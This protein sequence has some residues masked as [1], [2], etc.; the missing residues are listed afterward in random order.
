MSIEQKII[1]SGIGFLLTVIVGFWLI[2]SGKPYNT[3]I[4]TVHKLIALATVILTGILIANLLK[5][6]KFDIFI[7]IL[8]I[9]GIISVLALFISGALLSVGNIPYSVGKAIHVIAPISAFI[10]IGLSI[11]LML[12]KLR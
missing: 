2:N 9:M 3:G 5:G 12:K 10:S 4:F 1:C 6:I 8:I 7:I 11:F